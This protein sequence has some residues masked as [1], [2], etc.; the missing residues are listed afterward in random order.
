MLLAVP[1]L[2]KA[3]S[4]DLF[5][6]ILVS[7]CGRIYRVEYVKNKVVGVVV[8]GQESTKIYSPYPAG[9]YTNFS[10]CELSIDDPSLLIWS[11]SGSYLLPAV[12]C[13][14]QVGDKIRINSPESKYHNWVGEVNHIYYACTKAWV[15]ILCQQGIIEFMAESPALEPISPQE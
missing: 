1:R 14:W 6:G 15:K 2:R 9:S 5:P 4:N 11:D 12:N 8:P 10:R 13:R 7:Y 3:T